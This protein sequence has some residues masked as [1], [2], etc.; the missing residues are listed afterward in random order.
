[1]EKASN[2]KRMYTPQFSDQASISVRRLAW[3]IGKTMP[4]TVDLMVKILP[5]TINPKKVCLSCRDNGK[6]QGCIF[7]KQINPE[8]LAAL[9]A[10][11]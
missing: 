2:K 4:A 5:L 3:A 6:C 9:E 8:E 11:I 1:M 10:V 7:C